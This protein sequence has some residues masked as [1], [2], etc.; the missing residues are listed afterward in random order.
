MHLTQSYSYDTT[1]FSYITYLHA[2]TGSP[3][4][5]EEPTAQF[6]YFVR[7]INPKKKKVI[8]WYGHGMM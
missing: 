7:I 6:S 2:H 8:M 3:A 1:H 4:P 5:N